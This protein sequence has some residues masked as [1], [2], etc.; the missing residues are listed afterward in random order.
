MT[1]F[2]R[3]KKFVNDNRLFGER[4]NEIQERSKKIDFS[5]LTYYFKTSS[6][7]PIHFI[8]FKGPFVF[9]LRNERQ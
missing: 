1:N 4:L 2:Q 3:K 7:F 9:F 5:N 8:K 6:I